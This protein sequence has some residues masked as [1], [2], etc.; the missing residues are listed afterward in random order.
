MPERRVALRREHEARAGRQPRE[1]VG[2]ALEHVVHARRRADELGL[3]G[4]ALVLGD[5]AELEQAIDEQPQAGVGGHA[6][7]ACV[8][9]LQEAVLGE[10]LLPR[11]L[12]GM[13]L[14]GLGLAA[15]DGRPWRRLRARVR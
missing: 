12:T 14:I 2:G 3:D 5:V 8:R 6:A 15:I 1:R 9:G 13:A 7:G 11:H 4:R 10:V